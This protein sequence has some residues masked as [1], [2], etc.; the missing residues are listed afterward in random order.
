MSANCDS[1]DQDRVRSLALSTTHLQSHVLDNN[2]LFSKRK[3]KHLVELME[4]SS[5]VLHE[6]KT[7][8]FTDA[9]QLSKHLRNPRRNNLSGGIDIYYLHQSH[10]W[11]PLNASQDMIATLINHHNIGCGFLKTLGCFHARYLPTEETYAGPPRAVFT[12]NQSEFGWVYKYPEK[13]E[14]SS[15]DPWVIRHTGIYHVYNTKDLRSIFVILNPSPVAHFSQYLRQV[16]Q[17]PSSRSAIL[18]TPTIIHTMLL[19]THL[20]SW[21]DYMEDH[22]ALLLK[23]DMKPACTVLEEPLVTFDTLK[24]VRAIEK[25]ILPVEPLMAA[26]NELIHSL[27]QAGDRLS[28]ARDDNRDS[29]VEIHNSLEELRK[30]AMSYRNRGVYLQ[31]RAQL[32]AQSV[33]DSLNL[34]FQQLAKGQSQNT[35]QMARSAREDS[36]AIRAITLVTSFY[37]PFS[38]VATMFGMNLVDFDSESRNLLVSNQLWLYFIISVPLTVMTLACWRWRMQSYRRGYL[39]EESS[40]VKDEKSKDDSLEMDMV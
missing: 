22:E 18:S 11:A 30:E 21:R 31:K 36:V 15:G 29:R 39:E 19:S 33:L 37:L 27:Q 32:T 40:S 14:V 28:R 1:H 6:P 26:L 13:K 10:T 4:L 20:G 12:T 5:D 16:L 17:Q 8:S 24:E 7:F 34:G 38:F 23:L 2:R 3:E 35:F 9:L 25:R